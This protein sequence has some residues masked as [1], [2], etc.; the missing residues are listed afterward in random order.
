MSP[1]FEAEVMS[2]ALIHMEFKDME[3]YK[4]ETFFKI[5]TC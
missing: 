1:K 3:T 2:L 4:H 5:R